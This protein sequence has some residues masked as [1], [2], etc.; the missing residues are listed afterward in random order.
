M[1]QVTVFSRPIRLMF[2]IGNNFVQGFSVVYERE[3]GTSGSLN[4]WFG[5]IP[6]LVRFVDDGESRV[7]WEQ[8]TK[9]VKIKA[10]SSKTRPETTTEIKEI[11][12]R[13][14]AQI[15]RISG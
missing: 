15:P 13:R 6:S 14:D 11:L 8:T 1:D 7:V 4:V 5:T 10:F 9:E 12:I 3:D 2:G